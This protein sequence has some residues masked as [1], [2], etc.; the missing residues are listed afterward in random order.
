M[1]DSDESLVLEY[2]GEITNLRLTC[3]AAAQK[4]EQTA[5]G[6]IPTQRQATA[7]QDRTGPGRIYQGDDG[8]TWRLAS[9]VRVWQ[10]GT[11]GTARPSCGQPTHTGPLRSV[12]RP[13]LSRDTVR[14]AKSRRSVGIRATGGGVRVAGGVWWGRMRRLAAAF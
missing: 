3:R 10:R 6:W 12:G 4:L 1:Y 2:L 9:Q 7:V 8:D 5:Y 13:S 11:A 14:D